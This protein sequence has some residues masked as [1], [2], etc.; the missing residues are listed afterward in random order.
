MSGGY[1]DYRNDTLADELFGYQCDTSHG[2]KGDRHDAC[3]RTAI[4]NNPLGDPEVSALVYDVFCLLHSY[5]WAASGDTCSDSYRKD[6]ED[7]KKRWMKR[8]RKDQIR[9]LI[10]ICADNLKKEL[11]EAFS[12][13]LPPEDQ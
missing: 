1:W 3:L 10:D 2:L 6:V 12:L 9:E 13:E 7:F 4:K 11:Y 5:D 8:S